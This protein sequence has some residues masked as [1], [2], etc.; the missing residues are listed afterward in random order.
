MNNF[1]L[2]R[3]YENRRVFHI[4]VGNMNPEEVERNI[5]YFRQ[6]I[7]QSSRIPVEYFRR[8]MLNEPDIII[9]VRNNG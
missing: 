3:G 1:K 9:P 5:E 8:E 2:L 7:I 4:D 6:Q